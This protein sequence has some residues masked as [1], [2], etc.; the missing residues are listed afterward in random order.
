MCC[1]D[2]SCHADQEEV[3]KVGCG[4]LSRALEEQP[5]ELILFVLLNCRVTLGTSL[6]LGIAQ[7]PLLHGDFD[8]YMLYKIFDAL[9]MKNFIPVLN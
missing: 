2:S 4:L 9:W 6:N 1:C 5:R 7:Y 8:R 3:N